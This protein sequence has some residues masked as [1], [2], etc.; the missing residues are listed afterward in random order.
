MKLNK[1][2]LIA[3]SVFTSLT[4]G[5]NNT[6][7]G[8]GGAPAL[9]VSTSC[10][11]T[12]GTTV[13]ATYQN[14][15][16]NFGDVSCGSSGPDV[17]YS[18]VAPATGAVT[19]TTSS[20]SITDGVMALYESDCST[21]NTEIMCSD[22]VNGNMPEI[23]SGSLTPGQTYYIRFWQYGGGTGTFN[24]CVVENV[25]ASGDECSTA[26]VLSV[27]ANGTCT[28]FSA[29][30]NDATDSGLG[31][32]CFGTPNDDVWFSF[33]ATNDSVII[34]RDANF[35]SEIEVFT[36]CGGAVIGCEDAEGPILLTGL[37]VGQTYVFRIYAY[38]SFSP[39][40]GTF[41][42]CVYEPEVIQGDDCSVAEN[43]IV[44]AFGVCSAA[45]GD[46]NDASDSGVP[47]SC[48][49][50]PNDDLWYSFTATN[51]SIWVSR[52]ANF[53]SE[54]EVFDACGGNSL[55]CQDGEGDLLLTG[56][57]V[58]QTYYVR[59]YAY[60]SFSPFDGT[61]DI[62]VYEPEIITYSGNDACA[63]ATPITMSNTNQCV[64]ET[65]NVNTATSSGV[66]SSC[67]GTAD[68]DLWYSFVATNDS[69]V[70]SRTAN[71]DSEIAI[72][73]ACG[74]NELDCADAEGGLVLTGLTVGQ[75]Y[76]VQVYS[77]SSSSPIDGEFS[78]CVVSPSA[79]IANTTCPEMSPI[80][81]DS[82]ISFVAQ[83]GTAD[84]ETVEPGNN[85]DCLS[86]S[87]NPSWYYLEIAGGGQLSIDITA[88]SDV[89]YA[90]WGPFS[91]VVDAQLNCGGYTMPLDCSYSTSA[92]EQANVSAVQAG[93]VYVLLVT[94]Y[95]DQ[96]QVI[97]VNSAVS[98]TA[99]TDCQD[100]ILPV[101]GLELA[102]VHKHNV[103]M[104]Q[105]STESERNADYYMV[106]RSQDGKIWKDVQSVKAMG[107]TYQKSAYEIKDDQFYQ[108]VNYYRILQY[109][110]NESMSM[111]NIFTINNDIGKVIIA[112]YDL[113]GRPVEADYNG[114][115]IRV[116]SDGSVEKLNK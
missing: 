28:P 96:V 49:G 13:G 74:G 89:D 54:I 105:W 63:L 36:G 115:Q 70:V 72:Y 39:F 7:C 48:W 21:Y 25:P 46:V 32:S 101:N 92:I 103:N 55:D 81:A 80:C 26:N 23:S 106:Q 65:G 10:S 14:N 68:D 27:G 20:G 53:D 60:S 37:T 100:V 51:D 40:N 6:P 15:A 69:A 114:Y 47:S 102:V 84:A 97:N 9:T 43:L 109:D 77:Y 82:P 99:T 42:V 31:S 62:C 98:N 8:N 29:D 94:N 112:R 22:D 113:L 104:V 30:V 95:A 75:T 5:Q 88:G 83:E 50:T 93:Q 110:F 4:W 24:I 12:S 17:W 66:S 108:G 61:F 79:T 19:I 67:F 111:S 11:Y 59:V 44:G 86:T 52:N 73:D 16:N 64:S 57:T 34:E 18:F 33:V 87:P 71:F 78:L 107:T 58:G 1:T 38:S 91:S 2:F 35:D 41:D 3:C 90:I 116:Y 45:S 85:Y 76:Y 56:L